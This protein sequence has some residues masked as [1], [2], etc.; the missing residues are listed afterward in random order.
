[1]T[2]AKN[3]W[4]GDPFII[5]RTIAGGL[6]AGARPLSTR[7]PKP[8]MPRTGRGSGRA[9]SSS[10]MRETGARA[11][12]LQ[13]EPNPMMN[14][15]LKRLR[16]GDLVLST[17]EAC[18]LVD[19]H[20]TAQKARL[21]MENQERSLAA[22]MEP[23]FLGWLISHNKESE[24][25]ISKALD[26]Y[27][28]KDPLGSWARSQKGV[29]TMIAAGLLRHFNFM[30]PV[31]GTE[32][33]EP[34][35]ME[36]A[37]MPSR[38]WSF[39]GLAPPHIYS[40]GKGEKRPFN[41]RLKT[42]LLGHL[43]DSFVKLHNDPECFYGMIYAIQK[44]RELERN[45]AGEFAEQAKTTLEAHPKHANKKTYEAG[46]FPAGRI[47]RMARRAAVKIF[48]SN[49]HYV[50]YCIAFGELPPKPYVFS[51]LGHGDLVGP[52]GMVEYAKR[53]LK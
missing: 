42:I 46:Q 31:K 38:F 10:G 53:F 44:A 51:V 48:V 43:A 45:D 39:A 20:E 29:G 15:L 30:V 12:F 33:M 37:Q 41:M 5:P 11:F 4:P 40:W 34:R 24:M 13:G 21:A 28:A 3:K 27:T 32:E 9:R 25:A 17:E 14:E 1:M 7:A 6:R 47:D 35:P 2:G 23:E 36:R 22:S 52:P 49:Y 19:A 16:S 50:G 8:R 26:V 18:F